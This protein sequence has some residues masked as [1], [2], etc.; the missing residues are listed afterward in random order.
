MTECATDDD[1]LS[2]AF[3]ATENP[4]FGICRPVGRQVGTVLH[5]GQALIV[6][7]LRTYVCKCRVDEKIV[8]SDLIAWNRR[9][10]PIARMQLLPH[11]VNSGTGDRVARC[12]S[13]LCNLA[14]EG[15]ELDSRVQLPVVDGKAAHCT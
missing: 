2:S 5:D 10:R 15:A 13:V 7:Q 12:S 1:I 4:R 9:C 6:G 8:L 3:T 11:L 14:S